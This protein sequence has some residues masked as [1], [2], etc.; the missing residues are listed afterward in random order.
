VK[1]CTQK[2]IIIPDLKITKSSSRKPTH[3]RFSK[4]NKSLPHFSL[5]KISFDFMNFQQ[6]FFSIFNNSY[7]ISLKVAPLLIEDFPRYEE[8][9]GRQCDL[10]KIST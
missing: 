3:G 2:I 8:C 9:G 7:T 10:E 1:F 5:K 6:Q 4:I